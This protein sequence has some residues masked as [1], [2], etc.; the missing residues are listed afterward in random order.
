[1]SDGFGYKI[2]MLYAK[3]K[4]LNNK[5]HRVCF[6]T[7]RGYSPISIFFGGREQNMKNS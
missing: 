1:M 3:Y 7:F 6:I 5:V 4:S 2:Y